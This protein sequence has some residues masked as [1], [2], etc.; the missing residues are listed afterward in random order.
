[1]L[2]ASDAAQKAAH[3]L[4]EHVLISNLLELL[5]LVADS[6][7]S[8]GPRGDLGD[9]WE[10]AGSCVDGLQRGWYLFRL[11]VTPLHKGCNHLQEATKQEE[12]VITAYQ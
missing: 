1:M 8:T 9:V 6:R 11:G 10:G 2:Q 5:A 7:D 3:L 12:N 4:V